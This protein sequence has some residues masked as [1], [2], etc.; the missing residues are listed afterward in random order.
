MIWLMLVS[1]IL[2]G[3]LSTLFYSD[4]LFLPLFSVMVMVVTYPY[5]MHDKRNF[6]IAIGI[7]GL[8]YDVV[9]TNTFFLYVYIFVLIGLIIMLF[10]RFFRNQIINTLLI[11]FLSI[12][13][14][15]FLNYGFLVMIQ[16]KT[17]NLDELLK[18]IYQSFI[19]NGSYLIILYGLL[20]LYSYRKHKKNSHFVMSSKRNI[21]MFAKSIDN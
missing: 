11:G 3:I 7:L 14:F 9:Y 21:Q 12:C 2:D 8:L 4:S 16:I 19:L 15:R 13:L 10:F 1:F 17:F 20:K 5:M 18:S 6:L